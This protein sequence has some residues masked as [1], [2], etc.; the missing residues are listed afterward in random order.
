MC[1]ICWKSNLNFVTKIALCENFTELPEL[2]DTIECL[3]IAHTKITYIPKLPKNLIRFYCNDTRITSLPKIP[4]TLN[5]LDCSR[6]RMLEEKPILHRPGRL[7]TVGC[8]FRQKISESRSL[9][10]SPMN[11]S[12]KENSL[13]STPLRREMG[14]TCYDPDSPEPGTS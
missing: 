4:E 2:P 3:C 12:R 10:S 11:V 9:P 8:H 6:C 5:F 1:H 7:I 13:V 14:Y